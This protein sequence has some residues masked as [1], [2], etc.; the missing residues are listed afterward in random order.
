M[1][2]PLLAAELPGQKPAD[3]GLDSRR[4]LTDEVAAIFADARALWQVFQHR[5]QRLSAEDLATSVTR[6]AWGIPFFGLLGYEP[7]YNLRAFDV[8]G[9]TFAISHRAGEPED[10]PPI[11]I[12]GA[13]QE[14][15]HVAAS[16]RPR[17]APHSLVQE[18][19]NR[20]EHLW[21]IVTNG[22]TLWK[23]LSD[24]I[25][26]AFLKLAPLNGELFT[27]QA[28]DA[29]TLSNRDLLNAFWSLAW[30]QENS[31]SPLRRVNYAALDVE[32]FGSVY[33]SL[34]EFH[35]TVDHDATGQPE[36]KLIV[37][38]ERKAT[39]SYYTPPELV[40]ELIQ[41]ALEPV[42]R[43]RLATRPREPEK[44]LLAIRVCDP[45]CGSGHF[46]LAA[47]RR[48]GKEL[49]HVRTGEDEPA[50]ERV[51]EATRD[52][53]SHCIYGVDRNPLAVDLCR[54]ALWLE[55]HTG[56]KPLTFLDHRIRCGDSL[57]GVFDLERLK[58]GIPDKAFEPLEGDDRATAR[59]LARRNRE[60]RAGQMGLFVWNPGD[61]LADFTLKSHLLD[62]ITDDTPEAIRRK[63]QLFERS[64]AD[65]TWR[66]QKDA[67]D[68]WSASFFQPLKPDIPIIT[69]SALADYLGGRPIDA[70]L[71]AQASALSIR[72]G[73]FHWPL[74]FP[75][76]FA[77]GGFDV[78][79]SNPP[80][81][82]VKLQGQEFFATRDARIMSAPTKAARTKLIKELPETNPQLYR[83]YI[84]ALR[85][86]AGA[87]SLLRHGGRFPL[88]GCGDIN[89]Y[90][91]FAELA[92]SAMKPQGRAGLIV[93]T[94]IAT[95]DTTKLF[96][97]SL[98]NA[99]RLIDLIGF[100]N[101]EFI[102]LAVHH[103]FKFCKIT[104]G[105]G[106]H[107]VGH[108]RIGF[109]IRKFAQL[110]EEQ[111][112]FSLD[113]SD[114]SLLNPNTGNCPIFRSQADA[115]LTK[116][117]YR[118]VP[119]LWRETV[120]G[121]LEENP[122]RLSFSR[123]FDMANDSHHFRTAE[124][125]EADGYRWEG[126]VFVS[127]YDRYLPLY[128][129][130]MLHQF[131]HR[132]STYEGAT[133]KQLNVGILPQ[134]SAEQKRDPSFI[135]QPRYWVRE[136]VVD[137]AIPKYPEPLAMALQVVHRSSMQYVLAL[138]AA[139]FY[140]HRD[141]KKQA[142]KL[143]HIASSSTFD[144]AV[145][146]VFGAGIDEYHAK[147]LAQDFPLRED[148]VQAIASCLDAPESLARDLVERFSP[149]WFLGWRD[150]TNST[151]E[152]TTISAALPK[153][154]VGDTFL[155]MFSQ[156]VKA[157]PK[158][159]LIANLCVWW[160]GVVPICLLN[161][162]RCRQTKARRMH[163]LVVVAYN[164]CTPVCWAMRNNAGV[165]KCNESLY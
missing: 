133:E 42:I 156:S 21:G 126:N 108:S 76:V 9:R 35:P 120:A 129:A 64:H 63:K 2:D 26:A 85:A 56:N 97:S 40:N 46:L 109:Y 22:P 65:P 72:Q 136:E 79:H 10:T 138:W 146:R 98:V 81:E 69:S 41:S 12:V 150:I 161:S 148:D 115:E 135:V 32:E 33:E 87:S 48:L 44:A 84:E 107:I 57:V 149:K 71:I 6:D 62:A 117:I 73:F 36:F 14:L 59:A 16:G 13:R 7:R 113:K 78:I 119:V 51:R 123:M 164:N 30:Y 103:A 66:R 101:E 54:V 111:R 11:H 5:L 151:N 80:W 155:L 163:R 94:G 24:E 39:G 58:D 112:F 158:L 77:D 114:F 86:A 142:A 131:G 68:L 17:L 43:E 116:A 28:R 23:V 37:G 162:L 27:S 144:R 95:D 91:V 125:L 49:A 70:R 104:I 121:Q 102:F 105:G 29:F 60:E 38:S 19:L 152:R 50:P 128:E 132:F 118:R 1:L 110:S 96:F 137:S 106:E 82:R 52:A 15:G 88:T 20:T 45:A 25:L 143:L 134:P 89:T 165:R 154:A 157:Q 53:I 127:P 122:W 159:G 147:R 8:D 141:D 47:A 160:L 139:G 99:G 124:E 34:L 145:A 55:S 74:E 61:A 83:E 4:N 31:R 75:E 3:F 90:A 67:C 153:S 100:E 130:K 140:L 92:A 18:Y 93:P